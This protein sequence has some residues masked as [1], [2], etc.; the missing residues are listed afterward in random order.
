[1]VYKGFKNLTVEWYN[2]LWGILATKQSLF[3]WLS[4]KNIYCIETGGI[5]ACNKYAKLIKS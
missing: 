1:M 5:V 3:V 4:I 2:K